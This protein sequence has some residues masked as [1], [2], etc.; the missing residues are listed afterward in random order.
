MNTEEEIPDY[1]AFVNA[2]T[3]L[4][5]LIMKSLRR[6]YFSSFTREI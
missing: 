6:K 5:N 3:R 4:Q 1:K 2:V